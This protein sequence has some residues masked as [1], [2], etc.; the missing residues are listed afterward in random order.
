MKTAQAAKSKG[1][2][3]QLWIIKKQPFKKTDVLENTASSKTME[4][5]FHAGLKRT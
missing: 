4:H 1:K 2:D 5:F 3:L